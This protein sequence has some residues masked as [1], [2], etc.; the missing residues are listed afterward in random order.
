[1]VKV[2]KKIDSFPHLDL[3]VLLNSYM[4]GIFPMAESKIDES[5]FW[6]KPK[7]RGILPL[8]SFHTS[9]SLKRHI[10]KNR[11]IIK[12]NENFDLILNGCSNRKDTWINSTLSNTYKLLSKAGH[13]QS[14]EVFESNKLVG[15][16]FGININ[17]AFFGES[18]YSNSPNASK[19]ALKFLIERL[20]KCGYSLFDTQ[21][22]SDHLITLGAIEIT[23]NSYLTRLDKALKQE[24]KYAFY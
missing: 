5:V 3:D 9:K 2:N 23:Q 21:F 24:V 1:M 6:V 17:G 7:L 19:V 14:I 12:F 4:N 18:M 11:S 22:I 8:D 10:R 13:A 15:G 20:N 16:L